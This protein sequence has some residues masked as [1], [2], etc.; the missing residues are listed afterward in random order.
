MIPLRNFPDYVTRRFNASSAELRSPRALNL[1]E[2]PL[3]AIAKSNWNSEPMQA[4]FVIDGSL[5]AQRV[6]WPR[7]IGANQ[8]PNLQRGD[9]RILR[10][11]NSIF[12]PHLV[13][14]F[15]LIL[16]VL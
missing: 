6:R 2:S 8:Q 3:N 7:G 12:S 1:A 10:M 14:G 4:G 11:D 5:A 9:K 13:H 16:Q 15:L